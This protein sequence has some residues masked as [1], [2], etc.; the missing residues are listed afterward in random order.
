M[1]KVDNIKYREAKTKALHDEKLQ[2]LIATADAAKTDPEKRAAL[3]QYYT[4]L[5]EKILKIDGSIKKLV[6]TRL[7][8]S[9]NQ[10]DQRKVRPEDYPQEAS[11]SH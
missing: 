6:A 1:L 8:E 11:A 9:L 10:L 3:K 5:A 2:D 7:K 4:L